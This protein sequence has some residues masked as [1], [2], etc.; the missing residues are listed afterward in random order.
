MIANWA[1][2]LGELSIRAHCCYGVH[3]GKVKVNSSNLPLG[4]ENCHP[5]SGTHLARCSVT[6]C[7]FIFLDLRM[8]FLEIMLG[9][10]ATLKIE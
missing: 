3:Q 4:Q 1:V 10:W 7:E 9:K 6:R 8:M 5:S 2:R